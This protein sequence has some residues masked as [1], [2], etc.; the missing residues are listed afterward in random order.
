M[1]ASHVNM[2]NPFL[3]QQENQNKQKFF[4]GTEVLPKEYN[5]KNIFIKILP[6]GKSSF[7][8]KGICLTHRTELSF[9]HI[10]YLETFRD[11]KDHPAQEKIG[12]GADIPCRENCLSEQVGPS[13]GNHHHE[14][15]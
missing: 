6:L 15:G 8:I 4:G 11:H 10:H 1:A 9:C 3:L 14:C 2:V 7:S 5:L 12:V 13:L